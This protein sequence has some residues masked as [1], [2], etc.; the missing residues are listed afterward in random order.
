MKQ[1]HITDVYST[2]YNRTFNAAYPTASSFHKSIKLYH[3]IKVDIQQFLRDTKGK[4]IVIVGHSNTIPNF[5]N[6]LFGKD[7]Y[8]DIE[9]NNNDN[10]YIVTLN[11]EDISHVVI[12]IK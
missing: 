1:F 8:H 7:V 12:Q 5:V 10:L 3:P 4:N 2:D 11:G 6:K 9:D